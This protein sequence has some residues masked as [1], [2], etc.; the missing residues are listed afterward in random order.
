MIAKATK[1]KT[2]KAFSLGYH[3]L[4][5]RQGGLTLI[6]ALLTVFIFTLI[7]AKVIIPQQNRTLYENRL[8]VVANTAEQL[9]QAAMAYRADPSNSQRWPQTVDMLTPKYLPVF[10]NRT[11]WD[12]D[13]GFIEREGEVGLILKTNTGSAGNARALVYK[14]GSHARIDDDGTSVLISVVAPLDHFVQKLN[15]GHL[16]AG[17][18]VEDLSLLK[19]VIEVPFNRSTHEGE[20]DYLTVKRQLTM[21]VDNS[22]HIPKIKVAGSKPLNF[23]GSLEIDGS[24]VIQGSLNIYETLTAKQIIE[25]DQ[26]GSSRRYKK[27]IQPLE[28]EANKIYQLQTVSYDY[29]DTYKHYQKQLGGG[30]Q[31][32]LIAEQID[33]IIPELAIYQDGQPVNVDYEKL[34]VVI[35]KALQLLKQDLIMLQAEN[36]ALKAQVQTVV[37]T[38]QSP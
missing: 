13:W 34:T 3:S 31:L 29:R 35:L 19:Q 11:P 24:T 15:V 9:I 12:G 25:Q 28:I 37:E 21:G 33:E 4:P 22:G 14:I 32:G 16:V 1:H 17:D 27:N 6:P 18:I 38:P 2:S 36:Q 20:V 10:N 7:T 23:E 26:G 8:N 5:N 30:R